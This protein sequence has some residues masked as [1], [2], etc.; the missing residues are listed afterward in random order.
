VSSMSPSKT[1]RKRF[2]IKACSLLAIVIVLGSWFG[3]RFYIGIDGQEYKC[4]P[5]TLFIVDTHQRDIKR[6]QYFSYTARGMEPAVKNGDTAL[7][8]AAGVAGDKVVI[9][10]K[11]T[12]VNGVAQPNGVLHHLG[13]LDHLTLD[14][15]AKTLEV[16]DKEW[17]AM[18]TEPSSFDS[19]YWGT[20]K[21]DQI[22]GRAYPIF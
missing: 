7:K 9:G 5:F 1:D 12:L 19:R 13:K 15:L 10:A 22:Q 21:E 17:F 16:G 2:L 4:L 6:G 11:E 8:K 3:N 18:G 14:N 20:V